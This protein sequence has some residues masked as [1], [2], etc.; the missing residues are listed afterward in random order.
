MC[1]EGGFRGTH[2]PNVK[3]MDFNACRQRF[4]KIADPISVDSL[5]DGI[6]SK[7]DGF[8]QQAPG[9]DEDNQHNRETHDWVK[10]EPSRVDDCYPCEDNTERN[11]SIGCHVQKCPPDVY[12]TFTSR[13]EKQ[14]R[15][16]VDEN[17]DA[18]HN[19]HRFALHR[20]WF[21]ESS[22]GLPGDGPDRDQKDDS[23]DESRQNG[24]APK[25]VGAFRCRMTAG[26]DSRPPRES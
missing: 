6:E 10:P 24:G 2:P 11:A 16:R 4:Q 22:D 26:E 25:A 5:W 12:V 17:S 20:V 21:T 9:P 18:R 1:G 23:V 15:H 19:D 13:H 14:R 7:V 3:V 8:A